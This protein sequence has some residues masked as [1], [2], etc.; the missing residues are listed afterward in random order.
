MNNQISF[1]VLEV[2]A[3]NMPRTLVTYF[4]Q[5]KLGGL[6]PQK[7]VDSQ[8]STNLMMLSEMRKRFDKSLDIDCAS[9]AAIVS[10]IKQNQGD[11]SGD[12]TAQ[13]DKGL[14]GLLEFEKLPNKKKV[15]SAS[16]LSISEIAKKD[17]D[18]NAFGKA[19]AIIRANLQEI[20][21]Y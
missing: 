12:E 11:Y 7:F 9:R 15:E 20:I 18:K 19:S 10:K 8:I 14:A 3:G 1:D 17:G 13:I 21:A 4:A 16:P 2:T 5:V 6:I